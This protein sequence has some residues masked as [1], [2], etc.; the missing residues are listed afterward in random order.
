MDLTPIAPIARSEK[1]VLEKTAYMVTV[2]VWPLR[3]V[4]DPHRW[5]D[6]F[7][8]DERAVAL[9]ILDQFMYFSEELLDAAF[10]AGFQRISQS[11]LDPQHPLQL[12]QRWDD[13]LSS[14]LVAPVRGE[15]E[16]IAD[17]GYVFGR[18][19]R[20]VLGL[21]EENLVQPQEAVR[22]ARHRGRP[23]VFVDDFVG[24]GQQ[25]ITMWETLQL[26][27]VTNSG[28]PIFYAP[29]LSTEYGREAILRHCESLHLSAGQ[30]IPRE[31]SATVENSIFW[32][33]GKAEEYLAVVQ[34]ASMRAGIP[35]TGGASVDDWQGF[36]KLGLALAM[37]GSI[38]DATL[39]LRSGSGNLNRGISGIA[40]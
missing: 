18:K 17:S 31:Y 15:R 29:A 13:F 5:L 6:N 33:R 4:L 7:E 37:H 12:Y 38:P 25:M 35:D 11:M 30:L 19:A 22:Q 9:H 40:A 26:H 21:S 28:V 8:E 34:H 36:H 14:L 16:S 24:T 32:P 23:I 10:L 1:W 27:E 20:Q 3:S 39:G 2:R